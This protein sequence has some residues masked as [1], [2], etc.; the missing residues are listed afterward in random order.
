MV[1]I[2]YDDLE[3]LSREINERQYELSCCLCSTDDTM[4]H[5]KDAWHS[6]LSQS[7]IERYDAIRPEILKMDLL[8]MEMASCLEAL[9]TTLREL[10]SL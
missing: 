1:R 7:Y 9:S 3:A 6:E 4:R 8:L 10:K 5:L 2:K